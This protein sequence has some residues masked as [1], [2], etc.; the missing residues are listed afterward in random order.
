MFKSLNVKSMLIGGL[1]SLVVLMS[2]AGVPWLDNDYYGRFTA[3]GTNE[4]AFIVDTATGQAW[5]Y[6]ISDSFGMMG[7]PKSEEFFSPKLD[8]NEPRVVLR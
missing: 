2:F 8:V 7:I 4:G 6:V 3:V 5:A 1:L